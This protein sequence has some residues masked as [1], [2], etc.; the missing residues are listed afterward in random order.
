MPSH[1]V[2]N[3]LGL[4]YKSTIGI[5]TA[6]I[7]DVCKTPSPGG[8][9]PIPYPNIAQ[10]SSLKGGTKTV[11]AKGK[12]IAI[13][14]SQYGS[15][16][17]DEP[18]TAGGVKSNVNMKATDWITYS[19]DVKMDG[20]NACRHTDK[21]F[22]NNKN[23]A[24]LAGN[25]DPGNPGSNPLVIDCKNAPA[26]SKKKFTDCEKEEIC[27]KCAH[28]NKRA[29]SAIAKPKRGKK[30]TGPFAGHKRVPKATYR[31]NRKA[32]NKICAKLNRAARQGK[33]A[34]L[35]FHDGVSKKCKAELKKKAKANNYKGFSAD[36]SNE[37]QI[38]GHPTASQNLRWMSS[39]P[40]SWMGG[41]MK[42]FMC[43]RDNRGRTKGGP[44]TGVKPNCC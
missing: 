21:K 25:V 27:A 4:T 32:G 8:P 12:M 23:A 28:I 9:V 26:S 24:D 19:F 6:T 39:R 22:H 2:V 7:P 37:I 44:H 16:N 13:K 11:K 30:H 17:G 36:H 20:K 3:S 38:G 42:K 18:G 41:Q 40:N 14:G 43:P 15:S 33:P 34:N 10:Q 5:S 31:K 29:N 35:G 1:I